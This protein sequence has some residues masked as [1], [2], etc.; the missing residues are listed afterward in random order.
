MSSS[1]T[2]S[3]NLFSNRNYPT[4]VQ[5]NTF[6]PTISFI[7]ALVSQARITPW[8][9]AALFTELKLHAHSPSLLAKEDGGSS[10]SA[11]QSRGQS[12][13]LICL[14]QDCHS[15][16]GVIFPGLVSVVWE[17]E[18]WMQ[19]E[20]RR[21]MTNVHSRSW[22]TGEWKVARLRYHKSLKALP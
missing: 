5:C 21:T 10:S 3:I 2:G 14:P 11:T 6:C 7:L 15:G 17:R 19:N 22:G 20:D 4:H 18:E 12:P 16:V 1:E 9:R 8:K 13:R